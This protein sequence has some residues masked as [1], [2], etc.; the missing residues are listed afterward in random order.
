MTA[1]R[2]GAD[3]VSLG[4]MDVL[5]GEARILSGVL[6]AEVLVEESLTP[7]GRRLA[8]I[9]NETRNVELREDQ[10]RDVVAANIPVGEFCDPLA[11]VYLKRTPAASAY[12]CQPFDIDVFLE[13]N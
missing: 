1:R 2:C 10:P 3:I 4:G 7:L 5:R 9:A 8:G 11:F 13:A 6:L 12:A